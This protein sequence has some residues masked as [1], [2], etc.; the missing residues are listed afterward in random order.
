MTRPD[1]IQ[2]YGRTYARTEAAAVV[3]LFDARGTVSG[4]YRATA[5]GVY[6]SDLQGNERVFIRKD[7]LGPVSTGKLDDGRRF[8]MHSTSSLDDRWLGTPESYSAT[9]DGAKQLAA[10][11]YA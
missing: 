10:T 8:Y 1:L 11:L 2:L 9:C 4:M 7:G 6:L 5:A 3:T